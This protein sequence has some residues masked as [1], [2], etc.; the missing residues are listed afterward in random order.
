LAVVLV[1][2]S[3]WRVL[4]VQPRFWLPNLKTNLV[5]IIVGVSTVVLINQTASTIVAFLWV[6]LYSGWLLFL[7]PRSLELWVGL[8]S[9]WAQFIGFIALFMIPS[10]VQQPFVFCALAWLIAWSSA[11]HFFSN[12]EEP[13][14]RSLGLAW[15]FLIVQLTW[16]S[17]HWIQYYSISDIRITATTLII[18]ILAASFGSI[19]HT[20]K[21]GS[22]HRGLLLE[23]ALFAVA[24]LAVILSTAQWTARL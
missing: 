7:K 5:D 20:Y 11:R 24:L 2:L 9:F 3:K 23:N 14:Y 18:G 10:L 22:L 13:H 6:A 8:Q 12:Y 15:G 17:L 4:A 16:I 1:L 19:Y 21:K